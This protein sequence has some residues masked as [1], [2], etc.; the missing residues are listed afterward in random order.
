MLQRGA[1]LYHGILVDI[2]SPFY[3]YTYALYYLLAAVEL[4]Q[5]ALKG[6]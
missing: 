3:S 4:L 6:S 1:Y 2:V 5:M